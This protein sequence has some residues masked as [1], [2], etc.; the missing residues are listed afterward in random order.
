MPRRIRALPGALMALAAIATLVGCGGGHS[1]RDALRGYIEQVNT[2][3]RDGA[4]GIRRANTTYARFSEGKLTGVAAVRQLGLAEDELRTIRGRL[5]RLP[6]PPAAQTLRRR[7]LAV[8]AAD[9]G[10]AAEATRLATYVPAARRAMAPLP[11]AGRRLRADLARATSPVAQGA[12]LRTYGRDLAR[13]EARLR[14]LSP[15]PVLQASYNAQL[16]RL[17]TAHGLTRRL[18]T[19]I[20]AR[21]APAVARLLL[22]FRDINASAGGDLAAQRAAALAYRDRVRRVSLL[23]GALQREEQRLNRTIR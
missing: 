16:L 8:F 19:A 17:Y 20:A 10:L 6:A 22:R 18:R 13:I 14:L 11:G 7:L 21:D 1:A 12:A 9:I 2:I 3:Q 23:E 5:A 15:P 4:T